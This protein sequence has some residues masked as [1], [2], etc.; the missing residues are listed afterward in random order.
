MV[1][2]AEVI[3][4]GRQR[5]ILV[6]LGVV[7]VSSICF[8][9][10]VG[11]VRVPL[12]EALRIIA[13][14]LPLPLSFSEKSS[15]ALTTIILEFRLPRVITAAAVGT[16][17]AICGAVMQ[18]VFRNPLADPY[19]LG[20]AGGATAGVALV[21]VLGWAGMP[22]VV[23]VSAFLGGS[24]AVA[25]VYGVA[26]TGRAQAIH[27]VTLILAGVALAA[28][29]GA[30]TSLLLY[31]AGV[32]ERSGIVFWV[33]GGL[34]GADWFAVTL[35]VPAAVAGGTLMWA[36]YRELNAL[37]LG[38]EQAVHLGISAVHCKRLLLAVCTLLTGIAVSQSGTIGFVGLIIPHAMRLIVGPDHRW[39]LPASALA[40]AALLTLSDTAARVVIAPAELP[41]GI[42]TALLGCPFFLYLL[43]RRL[44]TR[45]VAGT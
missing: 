43:R 13:G 18:G 29:F 12:G 37:A 1:R 9:V 44:A 17:L 25:I 40:G 33:M 21:I 8:G 2:G 35:L 30:V 42:I 26:A 38:D 10:A 14:A 5:A 27:N 3:K 41:V 24:V 23:P 32:R 6:T 11:A 22:L 39:L 34:A 15:G 19:L 36:F 45:V 16:I 28:L 31:L 4:D 20:I 7:A